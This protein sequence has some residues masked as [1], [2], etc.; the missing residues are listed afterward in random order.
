MS[1]IRISPREVDQILKAMARPA[2]DLN[3]FMPISGEGRIVKSCR[4][5]ER[6]GFSAV[7]GFSYRVVHRKSAHR[8]PDSHSNI[9]SR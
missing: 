4:D 8:L 9:R 3:M 2:R 1:R 5:A 6:D 7:T